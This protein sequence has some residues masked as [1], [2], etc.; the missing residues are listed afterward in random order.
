MIK[1]PLNQ[2]MVEILSSYILKTTSNKNWA[3]MT[4]NS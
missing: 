2:E 3:V 4:T 1:M